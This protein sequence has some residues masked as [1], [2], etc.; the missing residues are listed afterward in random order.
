MTEISCTMNIDPTHIAHRCGTE[1]P[2]VVVK[3]L[4]AALA[5]AKARRDEILRDLG[6]VSIAIDGGDRRARFVQ[7]NLNKQEIAAGRLV[8]S[9]AKQIEM[10]GRHVKL[11]QAQADAV[12][13]AKARA[14]GNGA[15]RRLIQLEVRAP[16]GR[17]L[18]QWHKSVDD[19]RKSLQPGYEVTGEVIGSGVVSPIGDGAQPFMKALLDLQGDVLMEWLAERGIV[20]AD[21]QPVVVLPPNGR[22]MQ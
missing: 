10:A 7:G 1:D 2:R 5:D 11:A 18:R 15:A 4:E 3:D 22:D 21:K 13:E 19:A 8:Q 20:G 9:I 16:D 12:A 17:V 6:K 14:T